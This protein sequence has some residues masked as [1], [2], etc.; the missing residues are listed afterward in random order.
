MT[1]ENGP[2]RGATVLLVEDDD[3]VAHRHHLALHDAVVLA[4]RV[5]HLEVAAAPRE[6]LLLHDEVDDLVFRH[7]AVTVFV[8]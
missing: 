5:L 3:A 1:M 8:T 4:A 7:Q 2:G 6:E